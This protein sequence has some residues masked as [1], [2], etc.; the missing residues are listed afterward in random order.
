[1]KIFYD[2]SKFSVDELNIDLTQ[3]IEKQVHCSIY[4]V[5]KL[6]LTTQEEAKHLKTQSTIYSNNVRFTQNS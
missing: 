2:G 3:K 1:M 4:D 6:N 5:T